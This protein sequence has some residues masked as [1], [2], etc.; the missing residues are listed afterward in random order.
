MFLA[1]VFAVLALVIATVVDLKIREVPDTVSFGTMGVAIV[2]GIMTAVVE[3]SITPFLTMSY[4]LLLGAGIGAFMFF[5]GQWGGGDAKLITGLGGLFGLGSFFYQFLLF[6]VFAGA[7]YGLAY[8][9]FLA[10]RNRKEFGKAFKKRA[11]TKSMKVIR[12]VFQFLVFTALIIAFF[13]IDDVFTRV[14]LVLL[15]AGSYFLFYAWLFAKVLEESCMKKMILVKDLVE[16]DW[17]IGE[18]KIGKKTLVPAKYGVTKKQIVQL[19]KSSVKKVLVK[20]GIPFVPSFLLAY[21]LALY[22]ASLSWSF[23]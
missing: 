10:L 2:L 9:V 18:V 20:E 19:Q 8:G 17:I 3:Q 15:A 13:L 12:A 4:G 14:V 11:Y 7:F 22:A 5:A 23:F 1:H 16:G 21:L 6:I